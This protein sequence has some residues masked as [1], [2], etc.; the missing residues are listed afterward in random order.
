MRIA[1]NQKVFSPRSLNDALSII[2]RRPGCRIFAGGTH[3]QTAAAGKARI[4]QDILSLHN[5]E[6]LRRI[7]RSDRLLELGSMVTLERLIRLDDAIVPKGLRDTI[8]AIPQPG[9]RSLGTV[10]GNILVNPR[11]LSAFYYFSLS[12]GSAELRGPNGSRWV[13]IAKL[14]N[15]EN[16]VNINSEIL[17]RVRLPINVWS[18]QIF[19]KYDSRENGME[20][21]FCGLASVHR[22]M[23]E[24]IR[25]SYVFSEL[26]QMR[27]R[28]ADS[29]LTGKRL[30]LQDRDVRS[31]IK[32]FNNKWSDH[33]PEYLDD[34]LMHTR[35][36][37]LSAWFIHSLNK[38]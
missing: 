12:D 36:R 20:Y 25:V 3:V 27:N 18:H 35:L 6:E 14:R 2:K 30:P 16:Q 1:A 11:Y 23:L 34:E 17:T 26:P 4:Q 13:S 32:S 21:G 15:S 37:N 28:N 10:G 29:L 19:R 9:I 33:V 38:S 24:E 7:Y 22:G 5:I 8:L 31:Y